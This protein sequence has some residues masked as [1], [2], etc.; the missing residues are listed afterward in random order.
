M[1]VPGHYEITK[2]AIQELKL[3]YPEDAV[4]RDFAIQPQFGKI[5]TSEA[6]RVLADLPLEYSGRF[7]VGG[8]VIEMVDILNSPGLSTCKPGV[9]PAFRASASVSFR[10]GAKWA[11]GYIEAYGDEEDVS[12]VC[13]T[14]NNPAAGASCHDL[15]DV[16]DLG[17]VCNTSE[18]QRT[19]FMRATPKQSIKEAHRAALESIHSDLKAA[20]ATIRTTIDAATRRKR[21]L[22]AHSGALTEGTASML[23]GRAVH[24]VQDSFSKGHVIRDGSYDDED[25]PGAIKDIKSYAAQSVDN[26]TSDHTKEDEKWYDATRHTFS[27]SGRQAVAAT[28]EAIRVC[29]RMI[30]RHSHTT[31]HNPDWHAFTQKWLRLST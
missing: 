25:K 16:L 27:H 17:H 2:R 21:R 26:T 11:A 4:I 7:I 10:S 12:L 9:A 30:G 28:K 13:A 6:E 14:A 20:A 3:H 23:L 29:I 1:K 8:T 15:S 31:G 18:A 5:H 22:V 19:H 24:T